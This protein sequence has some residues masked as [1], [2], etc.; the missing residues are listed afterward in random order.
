MY[1]SN[2]LSSVFSVTSL[3]SPSPH[4]S[5]HYDVENPQSLSRS[6]SDGAST[7]AAVCTTDSPS[8][9]RR[10]TEELSGVGSDRSAR[11]KRNTTALEIAVMNVALMSL[12][13]LAYSKSEQLILVTFV[14]MIFSALAC[15]GI[16][17]AIVQLLIL[18]AVYKASF[19]I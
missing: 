8:G 9:R 15:L 16:Y 7:S 4:H 1:I 17:G 12:L 3:T 11:R 18:N 6:S 14:D 13:I 5:S 2:G 19:I 10:N